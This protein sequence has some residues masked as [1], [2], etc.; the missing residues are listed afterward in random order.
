MRKQL[1]AGTALVAAAMLVAG[2]ASA[3]DKKKMMKPLVSVGGYYEAVVGGILDEDTASETSGLDTR[4]DAEIY[5]NGKAKLDNGLTVST[6]MQLESQNNHSQAAGRGS[7]NLGDPIDEYSISVSGAFGKIILGGTGGAPVKMLTGLSGSW[8]TGVGETLNFD[9]S[10]VPS[11]AGNHYGLQHSRLDTG[12]SEKMTYISPK[13]GGFQIGLTYAPQ[14]QNHD[15]N[16]RP[17][18]DTEHHDGLEGAVSYTGKFGDVGFGVGAGMTAYQGANTSTLTACDRRN[19]PI[20]GPIPADCPMT[21][22]SDLSDWLVAARLDFGGGFRVA[23]AYKRVTNDNEA[24]Q[25]QLIDLGVRFVTGANSFSLVG[26]Q[27]EMDEDSRTHTAVMGSYARA[28]GPGVKVH[29]N[30]LWNE[31]ENA[32]GTAENTGLAGIGGIKVVF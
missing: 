20:R 21:N 22:T 29:M 18:A 12:D 23:G 9:N 15:D 27:G 19:A 25:S 1:M 26:S 5:F 28:L 24:T 14:R 3:Q 8:A 16:V 30:L 2:G 17:N 4:T 6:H 13:F 10:W 32:A 11:V 7:G 31:T